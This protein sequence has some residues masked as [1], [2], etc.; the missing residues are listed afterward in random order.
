MIGVDWGSSTVKWFDGKNFGTGI[1]E[2]RSFTVGVSSSQILVRESVYPICSGSKLKKLI[3]NDVA[4]DLSVEPEE[5]SV[6]FCQTERLEKGCSFLIFVEK[7]ERLREIPEKV[8]SRAQITVDILGGVAAALSFSDTFTLI[9]AGSKK[10]SLVNVE[11]GRLKRVE[12][13]RGG[14]SY[15]LKSRELFSLVEEM[16]SETVFLV[17]GGAFSEEFKEELSRVI[18]FSVPEVEPFGKET[19]LYFNAYGLYN[20]RKSPCRA[21]FKG[22]SLFSQDLLRDKKRLLFIGATITLSLLGITGG[23]FLNYLSVKRDYYLEKREFKRELSQIVGEEILAPEIQIPQKLSDY[24]ELSSFLKIN[25]PSLL[26]YIDGISKSTVEGVKVLA[27]DGT[28]SSGYFTVKGRAQ[29]N[30]SLNLFVANLKRYFKKV[31][32]SST[33]ETKSRLSFTVRAEVKGGNKQP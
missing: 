32:V 23:L 14:F 26:Y 6:A 25:E 30:K 8:S 9:D 24:R 1:P 19:P 15:Y 2:G 16:T 13:L 12:V 33:K 21:F 10:V 31:S 29:G 27:I 22:I 28:L 3:V 18:S 7:S 17:G 5:I 4:T 20:F 11:G